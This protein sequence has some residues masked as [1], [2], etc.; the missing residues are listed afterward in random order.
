MSG[1]KYVGQV[2]S[3]EGLKPDP[4]K[5]KTIV[6]YPQPQKKEDLRRFLGLVNYLGEFV[7]N[8]SAVSEPGPSHPTE[9]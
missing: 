4:D 9:E 1:L 2:V 8:L 3:S 6:K 5:V 7:Y